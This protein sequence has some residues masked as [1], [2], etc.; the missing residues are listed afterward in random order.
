MILIGYQREQKR[1]RG[2]YSY[3]SLIGFKQTQTLREK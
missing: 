2:N 1:R 3:N